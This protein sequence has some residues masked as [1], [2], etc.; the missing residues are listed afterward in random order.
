[1]NRPRRERRW[2]S[3]KDRAQ[4]AAELIEEAESLSES[5]LIAT[6]AD[7]VQATRPA[8]IRLEREVR[9]IATPPPE[10]V[11]APEIP[12][13]PVA[14][15]TTV[16]PHPSHP[17]RNPEQA[18]AELDRALGAAP[19]DA[20]CLLARA[21]LLGSLGNYA[22]ARRDLERVLSVSPD[23]G[24]ALT[25]LGIVLSRRGLWG[26]AATILRKAVTL[27]A[28][29]SAAWYYLGEALNR[30]DDLAGALAAFMRAAE[31]EPTHAKSY[32]GQGIVLDRLNRPE[33]ATR[34]YRRARDV[35][36]R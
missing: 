10:S 29:R 27:D 24:E 11:A 15:V 23:H 9:A 22:A 19:D 2:Q 13:E 6:P 1:M 5:G 26:E 30:L 36:R 16:G 28:A 4:V 35:S 17:A 20:A 18:L 12:A 25:A 31:L 3:P 7:L 34:M 33:D 14:S 8:P 32:Y 21:G